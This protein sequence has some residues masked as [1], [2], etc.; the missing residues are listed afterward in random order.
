MQ[1]NNLT[2][3]SKTH[4]EEGGVRKRRETVF[5]EKPSE[6]N[7]IYFQKI[8]SA[9]TRSESLKKRGVLIFVQKKNCLFYDFKDEGTSFKNS[10]REGAGRKNE[11]GVV[12]C[13]E[14][15]ELDK[16]IALS[17]QH[18]GERKKKGVCTTLLLHSMPPSSFFPLLSAQ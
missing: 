14:Q 12:R 11:R 4:L 17:G 8:I 6:K 3:G 7:K 2:R 16:T 9:N 13:G 5:R 15:I 1:I 10:L 18:A